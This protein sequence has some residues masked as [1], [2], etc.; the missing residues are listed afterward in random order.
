MMQLSLTGLKILSNP[1][2]ANFF[3]KTSL[4][5]S[6]APISQTCEDPSIAFDHT[7][8]SEV[9]LCSA[10]CPNGVRVSVYKG[11][12]TKHNHVDLIV[13]FIPPNQNQQNDTNLKLL[14]AAGG[15]ELQ[16][17]FDKKIS[18]LFKQ[19]AGDLFASH[20]G[21]LQ[22][23]QVLYC[24]IP[25]WSS[26]SGPNG[27]YYLLDCLG[28]V[29]GKT[30]SYNT[31]LFASACSLPLKYPADVFARNIIDS[32][33]SC[34]FIS[35]VLTVAVYVSEGSHG[36]EFEKHFQAS[37]CVSVTHTRK[38]TAITHGHAG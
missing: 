24:F 5:V 34:P 15:A 36:M 11:E 38:P 23:S 29:L 13:V 30:Q 6:S 27:E 3:G 12:F 21:K 35:S 10:T 7:H 20:P 9:K 32:I 37:N 31:I 4:E 26:N 2:T 17:D 28:K 16:E 1:P 8:L 25:P 14:F 33:T 19:S 22:C 18:Q